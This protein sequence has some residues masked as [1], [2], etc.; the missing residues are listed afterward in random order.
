MRERYTKIA[1][2]PASD[3]AIISTVIGRRSAILLATATI[4]AIEKPMIADQRTT[5]DVYMKDHNCTEF[6][7]IENR[8]LKPIVMRLLLSP[9]FLVGRLD[10]ANPPA[11]QETLPFGRW[12]PRAVRVRLLAITV[13]AHQENAVVNRLQRSL[14]PAVARQFPHAHHTWRGAFPVPSINVPLHTTKSCM[15]I[16]S[17]LVSAKRYFLAVLPIKV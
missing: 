9:C 8:V 1:A 5:L 6:I 14:H 2:Y 15:D 10:K 12:R 16:P 7:P 13:R 3:V 17:Q 11:V 4:A